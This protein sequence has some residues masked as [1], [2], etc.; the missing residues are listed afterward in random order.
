MYG[1]PSAGKAHDTKPP[2]PSRANKE[3]GNEKSKPIRL[4]LD[5]L[6]MRAHARILTRAMPQ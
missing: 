5:L 3:I 2:S 4:R 1:A 6:Y